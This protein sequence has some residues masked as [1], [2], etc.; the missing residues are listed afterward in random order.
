MIGSSSGCSAKVGS[1]RVAA[2]RGAAVESGATVLL[3]GNAT[4]IAAPDGHGYVNPT[5]H[6]ALATAG[7]GDVLSG[8]VG[9]LL[10]TGVEPAL[11]AARAAYLHGLAARHAV[12]EGPLVAGLL[13]AALR[14]VIAEI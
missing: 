7:S 1:D 4:V 9:S 11:A 14:Q 13:V 3:K 5:G 6:P 12:A 10:A 2:A 8:L